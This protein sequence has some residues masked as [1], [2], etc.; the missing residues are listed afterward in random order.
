MIIANSRKANS[1]VDYLIKSE[2]D[3]RTKELRHMTITRSQ[4]HF[5][6]DFGYHTFRSGRYSE[7][8]GVLCETAPENGIKNTSGIYDYLENLNYA[9]ANDDTMPTHPGILKI[10]S[11]VAIKRFIR[12]CGPATLIALA[13]VLTYP[14]VSMVA[15]GI[16]AMAGVVAGVRVYHTMHGQL[17]DANA[18]DFNMQSVLLGIEFIMTGVNFNAEVPDDSNKKVRHIYLPYFLQKTNEPAFRNLLAFFNEVRDRNTNKTVMVKVIPDFPC[19]LEKN[20][21]LPNPENNL[22]SWHD[23]PA[24]N[25]Q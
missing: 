5:A 24:N 16:A 2:V 20:D 15:F 10:A 7:T 17:K 25:L 3:P 19:N 1:L 8:P 12:C 4:G 13:T 22:F 23:V 9:L 6:T 21:L 14:L 18:L 11:I